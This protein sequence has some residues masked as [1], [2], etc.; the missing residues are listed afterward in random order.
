M[1]FSILY[2][3]TENYSNIWDQK[4]GSRLYW[5]SIPIETSFLVILPA[6]RSF[7][8]TYSF[9]CRN[10]WH[11]M[12]QRWQLA[13]AQPEYAMNWT[14]SAPS[15]EASN[16]TR[17]SRSGSDSNPIAS[18]DRLNMNRELSRF[19]LD[20]INFD[21]FTHLAYSDTF[22]YRNISFLIKK[23]LEMWMNWGKRKVESN[24]IL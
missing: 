22:L 12:C 19:W 11:T 21:A 2:I 16:P 15:A 24:L 1:I 8:L 14:P 10:D 9:V 7:S 17:I 20:E 13:H 4:R 5:L 18:G 6:D 23:V 3:F